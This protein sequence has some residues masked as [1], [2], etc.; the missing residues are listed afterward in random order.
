MARPRCTYANKEK[1]PSKLDCDLA[2]TSI[3]S[4]VKKHRKQKFREEPSRSYQCESCHQWH[5]TGQKK[6]SDETVGN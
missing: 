2:I 4:N 3:Q 5:M 1:F 6:R